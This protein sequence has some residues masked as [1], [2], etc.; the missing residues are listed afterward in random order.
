LGLA[1]VNGD[2]YPDLIVC[3]D[4]SDTLNVF[5]GDNTGTFTTTSIPIFGIAAPHSVAIADFDNDS[6]KDLVVVS[7]TGNEVTF[8]HGNNDGSFAVGA[9]YAT[10]LQPLSV[11]A[12]DLDGDAKLDLVVAN[13]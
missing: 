7:R 1:D 8:L 3:N 13:F 12:V 11:T 10:G 5:L 6:H 9:S 4:A 2:A